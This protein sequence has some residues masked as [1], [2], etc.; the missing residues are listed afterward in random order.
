MPVAEMRF[1]T[2]NGRKYLVQLCKHFAHKIEV[3]YTETEGRCVLPPGPA[4]LSADDTGLTAKVEAADE[5]GLAR[6]RH[7]I[8][9]HL[10][11]FAFREEPEFVWTDPSSTN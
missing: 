10:R 8:D 1:E 2:P 3:E 11:R 4:L 5:A 9:D 7:I 6:S